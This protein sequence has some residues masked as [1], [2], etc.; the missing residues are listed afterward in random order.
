MADNDIFLKLNL[1]SCDIRS[2]SYNQGNK[3]NKK[4]NKFKKKILK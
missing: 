2:E 4:S 1:K 3:Y